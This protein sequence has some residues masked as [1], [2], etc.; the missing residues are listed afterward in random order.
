[1][2]KLYQSKLNRG[3]GAGTK[4]FRHLANLAFKSLSDQPAASSSVNR[5]FIRIRQKTATKFPKIVTKCPVPAHKRAS[6][7][8]LLHFIFQVFNK[9]SHVL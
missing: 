4:I 8:P 9:M 7:F 5:I 1:M 6:N 2:I 3:G